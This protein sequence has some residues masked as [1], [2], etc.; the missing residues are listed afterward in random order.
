MSW[1]PEVR[2]VLHRQGARK[3]DKGPAGKDMTR[4]TSDETGQVDRANASELT[5][6]M[7]VHGLFLLPSPAEGNSWT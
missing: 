5:P 1:T 6:V 7:F 4:I 2:R 3:L